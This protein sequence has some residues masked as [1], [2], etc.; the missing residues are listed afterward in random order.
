[1]NGT[2]PIAGAG[3]Y[4]VGVNAVGNGCGVNDDGNAVGAYDGDGC[5][6]K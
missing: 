4:P 2:E 1:M 6:L 3:G 5:V